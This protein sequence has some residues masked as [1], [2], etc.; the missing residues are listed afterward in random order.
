MKKLKIFLSFAKERDW[1][2]SMA[3]QG[4]LLTNITLGVWYT[5]KEIEPCEK[6]FEIERFAVSKKPT[7][8]EITSRKNA[9]DI[10][11]Q[12]GWDL[13]TH[14]ESMNYYFVK[15]KAGD[16]TDE[17]YNDEETRRERA[18][19]YRKSYSIEQPL[20]LLMMELFLT[21]LYGGLYFLLGP[22]NN[23]YLLVVYL[24]ATAIELLCMCGNM[25]MGQQIYRD[26]CMSR[27]EWNLCQKYKEK[28]RFKRVIDM[29]S[30]FSGKNKAGLSVKDYEDKWF[31]YEEDSRDYEYFVDTIK[32]LR[33]RL[34][35][36]GNKLK[37]DFGLLWYEA[38]VSNAE[39]FGLKPIAVIN[40]TMLLYKR[41]ASDEPAPW[42][43]DNEK[44]DFSSPALTVAIIFGTLFSFG[45]IV[46]FLAAFIADI[47]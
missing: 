12:F 8:E 28:L 4:W 32:C 5:F 13:V 37:L 1:L 33:K 27:E 19:R 7:I 15:D 24:F 41:P 35:N 34:K 14:D 17:F 43:N 10:A 25:I 3:R 21:V 29:R 11:S 2:E 42:D 26:L 18:E 40:R 9:L 47:F 46:G 20:L 23:S 16:E 36:E 6:V 39:K 31:L 38:S 22:E 45:L 44:L 30:Y